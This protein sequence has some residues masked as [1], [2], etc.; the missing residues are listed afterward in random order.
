MFDEDVVDHI[1]KVLELLDLI[2]IPGVD[3]HRLRMKVFHLSLADDARQWWI[4]EKEGKITTWEELVEKFFCKFYLESHNGEDEMLNEGNNWGINPLEFISRVNSSF[5]NHMKVDGMTKK[6]S[7]YGNPLNTATD[8]FFKAHDERDIK[9]GNELRKMKRKG[10]NKNDE[11]PNKRDLAA[12]KSTKLVKYRSSGILLIME[13]LVKI[14]KKA[15]ILELK[16]RHLKITVLTSD[17]PYLSRKIRRICACT[18]QKTTKET[19]SIRRTNTTQ[20]KSSKALPKLKMSSEFSCSY[21][22]PQRQEMSVE[23]VTSGLVPKGQ[24]AS[25]YDNS[26]PVPLRQNVVPTAEKTNLSHQ[27]LE[28]LFSPLIEEYYTPTHGQ[29]EENNNDQASNASFQEDEF[30]NPFCTRVQE[31]GY[32]QEEVLKIIEENHYA[33]VA[34]IG[35]QFRFRCPHGTATTRNGFDDLDNP[36]KVY[37]SGKLCTTDPTIFFKIKY[38]RIFPTCEIYGGVDINY[39]FQMLIMPDALILAKALLEGHNSLV[40]NG[41]IELYFVRTEYQLADMFTKALPDDRFKYLVRRIGMRCVT[42]AELEVL[43]NETA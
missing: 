11:Q 4:N 36:E 32:A 40:E 10:E 34:R 21:L 29:A 24:K 39:H 31:T 2:K 6:K 9:E 13:Y 30:I 14:S 12:K 27:G 7:D 22:A 8:S 15:C 19:R 26:G 17:T 28:F 25:D 42:L 5:E 41:I 18:S 43:A 23:N 1:A 20:I 37:L 33:P 16:R 35:Y 3:S 38:G